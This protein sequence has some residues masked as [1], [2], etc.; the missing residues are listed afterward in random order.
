MLAARVYLGRFERLFHDHTDLRGCHLHRRPRHLDRHAGRLRG[1]ASS[2]RSSPLRHAVSAPRLRWLL[3]AVV[4]AIVCYIV[5]GVI[6]WYVSGFIVTPNQLVRER[7][8]IAH[9]IEMTRRA[10][11]LDRIETH[12]FPADTGVEA[13]DPAQQ[14]D[15]AREHTAVGLARAA[16]YAAADSGDPDLLRLSGHRHRSIRDRWF[17]APDDAGRTRAQRGEVA[18]EQPQLDQREA[19]LHPRLRRHD[20]SGERLHA[21]RAADARAQQHADPEHD[22]RAHRDAPGDLFRRAHQ[23]RCLRQD[24]PE[25][26]QLPAGRCQQSDLLPR[27]TAASGW[28]AGSAVR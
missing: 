17:G 18:A 2:A 15:D 8:F 20:E 22:S 5:V 3:A 25:G 16:G 1:A 9:N 19:D 6:G 7:P 27:A 11:A 10:Y 12:P 23:H 24:S 14:P 13:V 21:G 26:I 4:P 28:A